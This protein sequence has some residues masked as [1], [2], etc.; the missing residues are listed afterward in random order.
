MTPCGVRLVFV[1]NTV[2]R[3]LFHVG[4]QDDFA[5]DRNALVEHERNGV[6]GLGIQCSISMPLR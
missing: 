3:T 2:R 4:Q 6:D 5:G 1:G